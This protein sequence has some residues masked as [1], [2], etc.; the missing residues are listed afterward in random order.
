MTNTSDAT[1]APS[2]DAIKAKQNAAWSSGDYSILGA[3]LQITGESLAETMDVR[4]SSA[5]LD[6]AA[7]NGNATLA[8][9]RRWCE[10]TST[11][12]VPALLDRGRVRAEAEGHNIVFQVADAEALPFDDDSFDAVVSTFGVMFTP[13]QSKAAAEL[14]RVCCPG[15]KIG[16]ANWAAD[17][18]IGQLFKLVG[19][20][21]PPPA[22]VKPPVLWASKEWLHE[23][24]QDAARITITP[25]DFTFRYRSPDHF[26]DTFRTWYG[27]IHKAFQALD[28]SGRAYLEAGMQ[29][30]IDSMNVTSDGSMKV[31]GRYAEVVIVKS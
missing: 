7:A 29:T 18:F 24:F 11:D 13:D 10:V 23:T 25:R 4:P 16:M 27:P 22:G 12:Y 14:M 3:T 20:H 19:R 30:I 8:F 1:K 2:L 5:V 21:V 28:D 6:V 15:G 31:P 26:I 17:G 9:A